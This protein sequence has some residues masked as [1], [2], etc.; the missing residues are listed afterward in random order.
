MNYEQIKDIIYKYVSDNFG[1]NE[2]EDPSWS[3]DALAQ[4]LADE[5]SKDTY[6]LV[7]HTT[8]GGAVYLTDD[9]AF[10]NAKIIIRLDGGAEM[11]KCQVEA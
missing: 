4:H 5:L 2:A 3:I 1:E 10:A 8:D 11:L 9:H 7:K 6:T